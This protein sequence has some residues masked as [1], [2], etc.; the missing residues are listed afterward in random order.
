MSQNEAKSIIQ[1]V[2]VMHI[3]WVRWHVIYAFKS[4]NCFFKIF[5]HM[6]G[7]NPTRECLCC[8]LRKLVGQQLIY[9]VCE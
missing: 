8:I 3:H 7:V 4:I 5:L 2:S 9:G 6:F 1:V